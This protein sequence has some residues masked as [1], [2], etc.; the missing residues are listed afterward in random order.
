MRCH[1]RAHCAWTAV[2]T[3]PYCQAVPALL[4]PI[5]SIQSTSSM[6]RTERI[7]AAHT[8]R[9]SI[10]CMYCCGCTAC[11]RAESHAHCYIHQPAT[12]SL[13][14][15]TTTAPHNSF[16]SDPRPTRLSSPAA[17]PSYHTL[18]SFSI[19]H[20]CHLP[21]PSC[22]TSPSTI[23]LSSMAVLLPPATMLS[24]IHPSSRLSTD[25]P[26]TDSPSIPNSRSDP[27][28]PSSQSEHSTACT[29]CIPDTMLQDESLTSFIVVL[30]SALL[31]RR[32]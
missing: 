15:H 28:S 26:N 16:H 25:S 13:Y 18:E 3:V 9:L 6:N 21:A 8:L 23:T 7:P 31:V 27:C 24:S 1:H 30:F 11:S 29:A 5:S 2:L 32:L 19:V 12:S 22:P 20:L 10:G 4:G 14:R 17:P